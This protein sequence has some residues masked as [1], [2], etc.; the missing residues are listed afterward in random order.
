MVPAVVAE[1]IEYRSAS[2]AVP[3]IAL[4]V[5]PV[6]CVLWMLATWPRISLLTSCDE[7]PKKMTVAQAVNSRSDASVS[8]HTTQEV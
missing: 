8:P 1:M 7:H 4:A 6:N 5:V 2:V 3:Q